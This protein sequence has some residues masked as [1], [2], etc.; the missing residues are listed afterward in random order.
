MHA[1]NRYQDKDR[2]GYEEKNKG[3]EQK[4]HG[5]EVTMR[6]IRNQAKSEAGK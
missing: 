2:N 5:K 3:L 4:G 6:G 1:R